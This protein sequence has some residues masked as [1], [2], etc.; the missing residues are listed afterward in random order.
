[1][2]S[3]L[4]VVFATMAQMG[5]FSSCQD[6][7]FGYD[8]SEISAAA[9]KASGL[10]DFA[11]THDIAV[12]I[13]FNAPGSTSPVWIYDQNPYDEEGDLISGVQPLYAFFLKDGA[14]NGTIN[15]PT[16]TSKVWIATGGMG[17]PTL[18]EVNVEN[19]KIALSPKTRAVIPVG[20]TSTDVVDGQLS[21]DRYSYKKF[22]S[23]D[24]GLIENLE[25]TIA[26]YNTPE[27][28][29]TRKKV[30][31]KLCA[32]Y[33]WTVSGK[34]LKSSTS[35]LT[36]DEAPVV[37][38]AWYYNSSDAT[39]SQNGE[40]SQYLKEEPV[41]VDHAYTING[42]TCEYYLELPNTDSNNGITL[43][44]DEDDAGIFKIYF[45]DKDD[46]LSDLYVKNDK[47][48]WY[49]RKINIE[50]SGK[51]LK[52]LVKDLDPRVENLRYIEVPCSTDKANNITANTG[53]SSCSLQIAYI[54]YTTG[55]ADP[56]TH[57]CYFNES[58][59]VQD[60][61][62]IFTLSGTLSTYKTKEKQTHDVPQTITVGSSTYDHC[63]LL[64]STNNLNVT[65]P[66]YAS[67]DLT[68][69]VAEDEKA[70]IKVDGDK[71]T[72]NS[73]TLVV[74]LDNQTASPA[75]YTISRNDKDLHL[76]YAKLENHLDSNGEIDWYQATNS[77]NKVYSYKNAME[78]NT[79]Q[80][81][82]FVNRLQNT[83]WRGT[84]SKANAKSTYG[85]YFNQKYASAESDK[86][87]IKVTAET[88]LFVTFVGEYDA[89]SAN[90]FGYYVYLTN[91]RPTSIDDI[92]EMYV[93]FPNCTSSDYSGSRLYKKKNGSNYEYTQENLV[94]LKCGD[95]VQLVYKNSSD[96]YVKDFPAGVSVGWFIIYN[97]FDGWDLGNNT[98]T[99]GHVRLGALNNNGYGRTMM[100]TKIYFA[101][102]A[103]N[104]D[105]PLDNGSGSTQ[106]RCVQLT[107]KKANG[108]LTGYVALC[109]ED[110]YSKTDGH[111]GAQDKTYDDLIF[112]VKASNT[113]DI[114]NPS[115]QYTDGDE[116]QYVSYREEGIYA[117]EDIWDGS[118][119]DFDMNDV[120]VSYN[121]TYSIMYSPNELSTHNHITKVEEVYKVLNDGATYHD[122]FAVRLP[123][124]ASQIDK[125]KYTND[126]GNLVELSTSETTA[127]YLE[128]ESDGKV[129]IILF[130]DI[131]ASGLIGKVFDL[132]ITFKS[133]LATTDVGS[134]TDGNVST[135]TSSY[136]RAAYDPFII[137][138]NYHG[139]EGKRCEI[140]MPNKKTTSKG[141]V[142]LAQ[143]NANNRWYVA[144]LEESI[145]GDLTGDGLKIMPFAVDIPSID[146]QGCREGVFVT[147]D[148]P[149]FVSFATSKGQSNK[150]WYKNPDPG[151]RDIIK[152]E[153][154]Y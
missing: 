118:A 142:P 111:S 14:Y 122:A 148:Y 124:T 65:V 73:N 125:I 71:K 78:S 29:S 99:I 2:R 152:W 121:R 74:K 9:F 35:S 64:S 1:M 96:Q 5:F 80:F 49:D 15:L 42:R 141:V 16:A 109:F 61:D 128:E 11:M 37:S 89:F 31:E 114:E 133:P 48:E 82:G 27:L 146:F 112:T 130:D 95:Q 26:A 53:S 36:P 104:F 86:S 59:I 45:Y 33:P 75:V 151:K 110:S 30:Y 68:L 28:N 56:V 84:G 134:H 40:W 93:I 126:E 34:P 107:D 131:N 39:F 76:F 81:Q 115:D 79:A 145:Y 10:F 69:V 60:T 50:G 149:D 147:T 127:P 85:D 52:S 8:V 19:G 7:D 23:P 70:S 117:F 21:V 94:P 32:L 62:G 44:V 47:G 135:M 92:D 54:E 138:E 63:L 87:D 132:E 46:F 137:V 66:A 18:T 72:S 153:M 98:T 100:D 41:Y 123:Y 51:S 144:K 139:T 83:L 102:P 101:D 13:D 6:E 106:S 38:A 12:S 154:K 25:P 20:G 3:C 67:T 58:G 77:T 43:T 140:H 105:D 119:T 97:G 24:F 90:T 143:Y 150:E 22:D 17:L 120:A 108:D 116:N 55:S 103:L 57:Y 4:V 129:S 113:G 88:Q 91:N 136:N